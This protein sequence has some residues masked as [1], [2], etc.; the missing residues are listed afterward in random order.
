MEEFQDQIFIIGEYLLN[1]INR[2][3]LDKLMDSSSF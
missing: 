1:R 2:W 3:K